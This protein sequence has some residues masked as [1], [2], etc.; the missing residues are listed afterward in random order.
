MSRSVEHVTRQSP[1]TGMAARDPK[2]VLSNLIRDFESAIGVRFP[3][4]TDLE[5]ATLQLLE[6]LAKQE[7]RSKRE[8]DRT[9]LVAINDKFRLNHET[10][11]DFLMRA[12]RGG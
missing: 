2:K 1:T 12:A 7:P 9:L 8:R 6:K 3:L 11:Q 10:V 5:T 4:P